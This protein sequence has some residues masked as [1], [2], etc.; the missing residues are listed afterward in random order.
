MDD[1]A[2]TAKKEGDTYVINGQKSMVLNAESADAIVVSVRT[3][4]A[5]VDKNGISL[6]LVDADSKGVEM[7][8]FPTVDGLRASEISFENVEVDSSRLIG[9]TNEG[10]GILQEAT[11]DAILASVSYTHLTLPTIYS[12]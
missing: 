12:V 4:G 5:Q 11:N 1:V 8:N 9:P 7:E 10:F 2:T 6:F 3:D